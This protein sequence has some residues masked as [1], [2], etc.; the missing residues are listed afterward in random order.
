M[1]RS[2]Q[3]VH[4]TPKAFYLL[5]VLMDARPKALSNEELQQTIWPDTFASD[6]NLTG[7]IKEVRAAIADDARDSEHVKTLDGFGYSFASAVSVESDTAHAILVLP[8]QNATED[9]ELDYLCDGIAENVMNAF[10]RVPQLRVVSRRTAFRWKGEVVEAGKIGRQLGVDTVIT[11]RVTQLQNRM[12][13]QVEAVDVASARQFWGDRFLTSID[14]VLRVEENIPREIARALQLRLSISDQSRLDHRYTSNSR[15]YDLYLRGRYH[16]N[17]RTEEG[18]RKAISYFEA[19][20]ATDPAYALPHAGLAD[21]Y[22]AIGSRDLIPTREAFA[23][24]RAHAERAI[25]FDPLLAE[26]HASMAAIEE[27][28]YWQWAEAR[29]RYCRAIELN[30]SYASAYQ[31]YALHLARQGLAGE[32][33]LQMTKAIERDPLSVI[34]LTN[35]ALVAYLSRDYELAIRRVELALEIESQY[36]G[37]HLV[38]GAAQLMLGNYDAALSAFHNA[39]QSPNHQTHTD[40]ATGHALALSG[41]RAEALSIVE[42]LRAMRSERHV[43]S[44]DFAMI[45]IGLEM[46]DD[47]LEHFESAMREK[48]GWLVYLKTEPRLDPLRE[49]PRF[50]TLLKRVGLSQ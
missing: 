48:S 21:V 35:A 38:M 33:D 50:Q 7:L 13:I 25:E 40:A 41:R 9:P 16:W 2:G 27:V 23:L 18:L 29:R 30:P 45:F 26:A 32:A 36:E 6:V 47:A 11:G 49:F 19:A 8:F 39:S 15:A 24:G 44:I 1:L 10:S 34:I 22:V 12:T 17:K 14:D 37:T 3:S 5:T 20:A 46:F 31:W 28:H 42:R 4:L 43:S